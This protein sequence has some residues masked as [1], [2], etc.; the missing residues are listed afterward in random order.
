MKGKASVEQ[1]E[2]WKKQHGEVFEIKAD[3]KVGYIRAP[4]RAEV[5]LAFSYMATNPLKS[6]E[7]ILQSCWLGGCEDL[8]N[9]DKY[10]YS[11]NAQINEIIEVAE[12]KIKKL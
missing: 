3:D 7:T 1:I 10:F 11:I 6:T 8:R 2:N 4:K 9:D 12:V 5:G